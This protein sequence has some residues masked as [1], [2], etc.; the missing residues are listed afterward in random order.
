MHSKQKGN[1]GSTA[2]VLILQK[3]GF[4]VF[5]EIGDY[6]KVDL[7]A[8]KDCILKK[9]QVKYVSIRNNTVKLKIQKSGPNG[10]RYSYTAKDVDWFAL[11]SHESE[12]VFWVDA[13]LACSNK[14]GIVIRLKDSKNNQ[15]KDIRPSSDYGIDK[16]LK[17]FSI[18]NS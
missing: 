14:T 8:E 12:E 11:Y 9:I 4:N 18:T 1:I 13:D 3:N 7:I 6:S 16:F 5:S 2:V 10:Y 17:S 15:L